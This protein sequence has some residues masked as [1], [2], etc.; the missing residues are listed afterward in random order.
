MAFRYS[1]V[2]WRGQQ[3][4]AADAIRT[5]GDQIMDL[6]GSTVSYATDGTVASKNHDLV[7]PTSDHSPQP[8]TGVGIVRAIDFH[9]W[10]PGAVD[11]VCE[12]LRQSRDPRIKY[13]I[14]GGRL[15]ASYW[16]PNGEPWEW[17]AYSGSNPHDTHGHLSV[18]PSGDNDPS[19]FQIILE[20]QEAEMALTPKAENTA[21]DLVAV[22]EAAGA[23]TRDSRRALLTKLVAL[24][25]AIPS[26]ASSDTVLAELVKR[27]QNG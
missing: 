25:D 19:P 3:W 27:I 5:F 18:L 24:V 16:S 10:K 26:G 23:G 4:K 15:F 20:S 21:E 7:S 11:D 2:N 6:R 12:A 13:V 17:R 8:K 14:H 1:G 9:E 22:L